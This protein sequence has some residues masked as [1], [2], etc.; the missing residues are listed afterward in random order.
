MILKARMKWNGM[1]RYLEIQY[2][3]NFETEVQS[4]DFRL[5]MKI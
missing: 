4:I 3:P 2:K 5:L 1:E